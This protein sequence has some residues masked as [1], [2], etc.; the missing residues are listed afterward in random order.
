MAIK[1]EILQNI[2][3][4]AASA[5]EIKGKKGVYNPEEYNKVMAKSRAM[6]LVNENADGYFKSEPKEGAIEFD[7]ISGRL[8]K[9]N[10][11]APTMLDLGRYTANRY[12][13]ESYGIPDKGQKQ[14][15][16]A[17][18]YILAVFGEAIVKAVA[19]VQEMPPTVKAFRFKKKTS[20]ESTSWEYVGAELVESKE[21]YTWTRTLNEEAALELLLKV[22]GDE[23]RSESVKGDSLDD[24]K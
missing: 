18:T 5:K 24:I 7:E 16:S 1:A 11:T 22:E 8:K 14:R 6:G 20:G 13:V 23:K 2:L 9:I 10:R 15:H 19:N 17:G 3:S 4:D 21:V 12:I